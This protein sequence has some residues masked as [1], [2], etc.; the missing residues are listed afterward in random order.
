VRVRIGKA[1]RASGPLRHPFTVATYL[2]SS[3][4]KVLLASHHLGSFRDEISRLPLE[5]FGAEAGPSDPFISLDA[6]ADSFALL[7]QSPPNAI[8]EIVGRIA[9]SARYRELSEQ[10]NRAGHRGVLSQK[11]SFSQEKGLRLETVEREDAGE[12]L[13]RLFV[14][15]Q[16]A[17]RLLQGVAC[18]QGWSGYELAYLLNRWPPLGPFPAYVASTP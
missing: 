9:S 7:A 6:H 14:W 10:R 3:T 15:T 11:R 8:T 5:A 17:V 18:Y 16:H 4:R 12:V 1:E 13:R 2:G